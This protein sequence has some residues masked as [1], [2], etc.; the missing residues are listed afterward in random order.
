M[1]A[2][3]QYEFWLTLSTYQQIKVENHTTDLHFQSI[4]VLRNRKAC[5]TAM[6]LLIITVLCVF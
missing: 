4:H 5:P 3:V 6:T 2:R 1:F